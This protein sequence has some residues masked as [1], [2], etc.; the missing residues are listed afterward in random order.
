[1]TK[2]SILSLCGILFLLFAQNQ[3]ADNFEKFIKAI[4]QVESSGRLGEIYGDNG[5]SLG[6]LQIGKLYYRDAKEF[7]NGKLKGSYSDVS[8]LTYAKKV[9]FYYLSRYESRALK[10]GDFESMARAHN[11]G[12]KWRGK[13]H[14][15]NR[16]WQKVKKQLE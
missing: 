16:Y 6:P 13:R 4:H 10:S 12:P 9:V 8:D 15:T 14:L 2:I 3:K 1:M 11:G 5:R 7:A